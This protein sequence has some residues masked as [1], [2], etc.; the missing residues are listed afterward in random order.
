VEEK[1]RGRLKD[2]RDAI[3]VSA[4]AVIAAEDMLVEAVLDETANEQIE[5]TIVI[6]VEPNSAG[7]PTRAGEPG[8]FSYVGKSTIAIIVVENALA[9]GSDKDIG[10]PVVVII[11]DSDPHAKSPACHTGL[12]GHISEGAIAVILV[13]GIPERPGWLEEVT[14]AAVDKI[15]IHPAIVI[16][17]E[18]GD[19]GPE[20]LR[21][22]A[23]G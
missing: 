6:I 11:A 7:R 19:P 12:L 20:R 8:F 17:I 13:E 16:I 9:V 4:N 2:P 1:A 5:I 10:K 18:K 23:L 22:I 21:Q 3:V 15:D 14:G